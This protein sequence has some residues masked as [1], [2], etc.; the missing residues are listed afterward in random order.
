MIVEAL[1]CGIPVVSTDCPSGPAEILENG[2]WGRLVPVGDANALSSAIAKAL[3][4]EHDAQA[5]ARRAANFSPDVIADKY[6]NLIFTKREN[7][8][9]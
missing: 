2:R 7:R 9:Q 5:L 8:P 3:D 4:A 6:L 1:S